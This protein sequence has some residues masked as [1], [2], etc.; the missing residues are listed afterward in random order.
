MQRR[1]AEQQRPAAPSP[2]SPRNS[3]VGAAAGTPTRRHTPHAVAAA[4][5]PLPSE[6]SAK[7]AFAAIREHHTDVLRKYLTQDPMGSHECAHCTANHDQEVSTPE[8]EKGEKCEKCALAA[9]AASTT[10][11]AG[12]SPATPRRGSL[13]ARSRPGDPNARDDCGESLIHWAIRESQVEMVGLLLSHGANIDTLSLSGL[14]P[15]QRA[16]NGYDVPICTLLL[17]RGASVN[18]K[19][20]AQLND[21]RS[22]MN[23]ADPWARDFH[24]AA[25]QTPF[26]GPASTPS[27]PSSLSQTAFSTPTSRSASPTPAHLLQHFQQVGGSH[28]TPERLRRPSGGPVLSQSNLFGYQSPIPSRAP[29]PTPMMRQYSRDIVPNTPPLHECSPLTIAGNAA[30]SIRAEQVCK[31][32]LESGANPN[33]DMDCET[34]VQLR[35][36]KL[37]R[38]EQGAASPK[39][40]TPAL[41]NVA[42][43]SAAGSF[44]APLILTP[45]LSRSRDAAESLIDQPTSEHVSPTS[46]QESSSTNGPQTRASTRRRLC[47]SGEV[48]AASA[49][50][51]P[52]PAVAELDGSNNSS[53]NNSSSNNSNNSNTNATQITDSQRIVTRAAAA[54][55]A[56]G[57]SPAASPTASPASRKAAPR[58]QLA[59]NAAMI[60]SPTK[61]SPARPAFSLGLIPAVPALPPMPVTRV[62][63]T[64]PETPLLLVLMD[65][66]TS[67]IPALL[68]K[69]G[70]DVNRGS[71]ITGKTP[72][73]YACMNGHYD[74]ARL[75]L[76]RGADV[77]ARDRQGHDALFWAVNPRNA[78][79]TRSANS[80]QEQLVDMLLNMG[81]RVSNRTTNGECCF[82]RAIRYGNPRVVRRLLLCGADPNMVSSDVLPLQIAIDASND[83]LVQLLWKAGADPYRLT[84]TYRTKLKDLLARRDPSVRTAPI[85]RPL[86]SLE[87]LC[88]RAIR[89]HHTA[90][91]VQAMEISQPTKD[92][93]LEGPV[94]LF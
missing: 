68:M 77:G 87:V 29:S 53:S 82:L 88:Q 57:S 75:L 2:M 36:R 59:T 71:Q 60:H 55:A 61:A 9:A 83:D 27:T 26:F 17:Q 14:T 56:A 48:D 79:R 37:Q 40:A 54:A 39:Q 86:L 64:A 93:L 52:A 4:T 78:H 19:S 81:A 30:N 31:L 70:A 63:Y 47:Q 84:E 21:L 51:A 58:Q 34:S 6:I 73:H 8:T 49:I 80:P 43:A 46:S 33:G 91:E 89:S 38:G 1:S 85:V 92:L 32:L 24:R 66:R 20:Q 23:G 11:R 25:G 5:G 18:G 15:L 35:L 74:M 3:A 67:Y 76:E 94:D 62:Y 50:A 45:P 44:S 28:H 72:L 69:F 16:A 65:E 90:Q 7:A 42:A 13:E 22:P 12:R 10:A 41:R